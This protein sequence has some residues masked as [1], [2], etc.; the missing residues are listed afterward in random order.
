MKAINKA[1][2][3]IFDAL[4][5]DLVKVGDHKKIENGAF[6]PL[7][8]EV[9]DKQ[10]PNSVRISF[11]H[12]GEQNGDLMRD[13]E[14]CFIRILGE[15][16]GYYPY[17]FRNDY[18]GVEQFPVEFNANGAMLGYNEKQQRDIAVFAGQWASNLKEQGFTE[19]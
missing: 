9:I 4:T 14:I 2:K 3:A 6:M 18:L 17:Y 19:A 16:G 8:I 1:A 10:G 13:P 12:Y 5:S 15:H 7:S 11:C